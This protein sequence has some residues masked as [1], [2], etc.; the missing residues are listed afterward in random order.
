[1]VRITLVFKSDRSTCSTANPRILWATAGVQWKD[2]RRLLQCR[3]LP[4]CWPI[5]EIRETY[6]NVTRGAAAALSRRPVRS[7]VSPN[8]SPA[9]QLLLCSFNVP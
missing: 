6:A 4:D 7:P 5:A 3:R 8:C 2:V 1:M 9:A